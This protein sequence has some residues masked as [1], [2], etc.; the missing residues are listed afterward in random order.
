MPSGLL[1]PN[2]Q[3][4]GVSAN[5]GPAEPDPNAPVECL[6]AFLVYQEY[7][8]EWHVVSIDQEVVARRDPTF[9]DMTAAAANLVQYPYLTVLDEGVVPDAETAFI[10]F[11]LLNGLWQVATKIDAPLMPQRTFRLPDVIG[12]LA[13]TARDV[14]TR[15]IAQETAQAVVNAQFQLGQA[16]AQQRQSAQVQAALQAEQDEARRRGGR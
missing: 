16:I 9:D 12:G 11:Q 6:L 3:P 13:V 5:T 1:L 7:D 8:G 4:A 15:E 2:G 10:V 14:H